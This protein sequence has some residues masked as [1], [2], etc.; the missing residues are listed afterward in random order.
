MSVTRVRPMS[1][2]DFLAWEE[3]QEGK[4]EFDGFAPVA[5]VGVT[6]AHSAIQRN[7]LFALTGRLRGRPCQA[8]GSELKIQVVGRIRYPDAFVVCTP[9]GNG[10]TI[11]TDPVVIFEIV[12]NESDRRDRIIKNEEYSLTPSVQRY[13]MLEQDVPAALVFAREGDRWI[14]TLHK[15][16]AVLA[17]PEIGIEIPLAEFYEGLDLAPADLPA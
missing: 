7:V 8:H 5:M 2:S 13:V 17:M 1:L 15:D 6:V 16:D 11:I 4:Y 14:G 10:E 9:R 12:S 3:R